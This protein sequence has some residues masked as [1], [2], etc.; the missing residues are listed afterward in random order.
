M[1]CERNIRMLPLWERDDNG[2]CCCKNGDVCRQKHP[3]IKWQ[4]PE[5]GQVGAT[6][7]SI[8]VLG[9]NNVWP[10]A[11][12]AMVL[13]DLFVVDI[14]KKYGG[15]ESLA[16]VEVDYPELMWPT[17]VQ[18]TPSGGLQFVYRQ[19][20]E[21]DIYTIP[22]GRLPSWLTGWE[23]K[24][25]KTDGTSGHYVGVPPSR[26]RRWRE[27]WMRDEYAAEAT[28][29]LLKVLRAAKPVESF[30]SSRGGS[31]FNGVSFNWETALTY[32][33]VTSN[34]DDCLYRAACSLRMHDASDEVALP[35]LLQ[36]VACFV[37][38]DPLDPWRSEHA[39]LKWQ[40]VKAKFPPGSVDL[41]DT[42]DRWRRRVLGT[43][44]SDEGEEI[45][46]TQIGT[47]SIVRRP[48]TRRKWL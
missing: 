17:L 33:A 35:K 23:I 12:W 4:N 11:D 24:G 44:K 26:D 45:P 39:V 25:L 20:P 6:A 19:P 28:P 1:Y 29:Q 16:A 9:W 46:I 5:P 2:R 48:E 27:G 22:Q 40:Y 42:Q 43:W 21:R 13:D 18:E 32:G 47:K 38:L 10:N 41:T 15:L 7:D 36:V 37:N 31:D 14:D 30:G 8:T 34:Q 3:R